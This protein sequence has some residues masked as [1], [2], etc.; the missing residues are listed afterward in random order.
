[1]TMSPR[2]TTGAGALL[3]ALLVAPPAAAPLAGQ[4]LWT[5]ERADGSAPAGV[6]ADRTLPVG[7]V[8]LSYRFGRRTLDGNLFNSQTISLE[9]IFLAS[10]EV[11]PVSRTVTTHAPGVAFSPLDRLTV[12]AVLPF[13]SSTMDHLTADGLAY[14]TESSGV[15]DLAVRGLYAAYDRSRKRVHFMLGLTFPTGSV[16]ARDVT[17][18]GDD[19]PEI[20]TYPMQLGAGSVGV[21][22]GVTIRGQSDRWSWGLQ[23][24]GTLHIRENSRQ[25]RAGDR[26]TGSFWVSRPWTSWISNS[27]RIAFNAWANPWGHDDALL[28]RE[29]DEPAADARRQAGTRLD[30]LLGL[31]LRLPDG[32]LEGHRL[33]VE[34]GVPLRQSLEGPQLETDW[35]VQAGWHY[36]FRL[37]ADEGG[38]GTDGVPQGPR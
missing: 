10:Y 4:T 34:G 15:G 2:T 28:A 29:R 26:A 12:E 8:L 20:L 21:N 9:D 19:D 33:E 11:T 13:T 25:Y 7:E 3:V 36:P 6:A 23:L 27:A 17:P 14:T 38:A 1:M 32:F 18:L 30:L 37:F 22:P 31:N 5:P 35:I 24:Q 16:T